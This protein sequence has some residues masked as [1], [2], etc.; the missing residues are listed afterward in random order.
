MVKLRAITREEAAEG[1][2]EASPREQDEEDADEEQGD[3]PDADTHEKA[4]AK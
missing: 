2:S 1:T 3:E 4:E